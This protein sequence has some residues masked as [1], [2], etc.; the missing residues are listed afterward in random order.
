MWLLKLHFAISVL[1][2]LTFTGFKVV[3]KEII[4]QNGWLDD[5]VKK[6]KLS[7]YWIFFVPIMNV[8]IVAMVFVMIGMKKD[9][10]D[11]KLEEINNK[12]KE[13]YK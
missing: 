13:H 4:K 6:K 3:G 5:E 11:K 9:D 10:F 1:C 2:L 7:A 8:F 12:N